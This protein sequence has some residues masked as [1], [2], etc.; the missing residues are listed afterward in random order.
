M[1]ETV[2]GKRSSVAVVAVDMGYGHLRAAHALASHLGV[3]VEEIDRPPLA[4]VEEQA[5]WQRARSAYELISRASQ[6]PL[7]GRA[8][9]AVLDAVTDIPHL[10]PRRDQSAPSAAVRA[11]EGLRRSG[12]GEGLLARL[13]RDNATL[14]TTFYAPAVFADLAGWP[15]I[16]CVVTDSDLHRVW[17]PRDPAGSAIHYCVPSTRA[18]RRLR[19][20][21]VPAERI[22]FTG[23]PLPDELVGG[24]ELIPLR[25]NLAGRL[26]RLDPKGA[27]REQLREPV[28]RML[29]PLPEKEQGKPPLLV[30]AVGGAGAQAGLAA[31][32]LPSLAAPLRGGKLRL[33]LVAGVREEVGAAFV[34]VLERCGLHDQ[35]G[36]AVSI[37]LEPTVTAYLSRFT[38]L[39]GDADMVWTKPSEVSFFAALGLPLVLGHPVGVH[40]RY[41]RRWVLH[42]GAGL[43]QESPGHAWGWLREWLEDGT[44]AAAAW[45]GYTLL[46]KHGTYRVAEVVRSLAG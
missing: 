25:A 44:L 45:S 22:H 5:H 16:V 17:V 39:L 11:L 2:F 1:V 4:G 15:R 21:G 34:R 12:H 37:V 41:N 23:F 8:A 18:L 46:P 32:F 33:A 14:L 26:V 3:G 27:F 29:G 13:N 9:R 40:E 43:K 31:E 28:A 38:A 24:D 35:L 36:G 19:A 20:Y 6:M 10:Y 7:L 42:Q 30:F